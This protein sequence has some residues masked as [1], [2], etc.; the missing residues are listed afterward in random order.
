MDILRQNSV[1]KSK[2]LFGSDAFRPERVSQRQ[3]LLPHDLE[4]SHCGLPVSRCPRRRFCSA[5]Y[6]LGRIRSERDEVVVTATIAGL[7][8]LKSRRRRSAWKEQVAMNLSAIGGFLLLK[9]SV[10]QGEQTVGQDRRC[11]MEA[12]YAVPSRWRSGL[13][14]AHPDI[15]TGIAVSQAMSATS[16]S[17]SRNVRLYSCGATASRCTREDGNHHEMRNT[18]VKQPQANLSGIF[19]STDAVRGVGYIVANGLQV[20]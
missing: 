19:R 4:G 9:Q 16:R 11:E 6:L 10:A 20:C 12:D 7:R 8:T 1:G 13:A 2:P 17:D 15:S 5:C 3:F 14:T 18:G